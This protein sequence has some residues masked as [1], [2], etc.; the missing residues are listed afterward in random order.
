MRLTS[1]TDYSLRVLM[2]LAVKPE[3]L[4]TIPDIAKA[5][6]ISEN[7]LMKVVHAM[8]QQGWLATTRGKGGG[9]H[10]MDGYVLD[11][12][13]LSE[14][15][16]DDIMAALSALNRTGPATMRATRRPCA[17]AACSTTV[18]TY[19]HIAFG[20]HVCIPADATAITTNTPFVDHFL[21]ARTAILIQQ[22]R[23]LF[24]FV[25]F[26]WL[27]H[28]SV[29]FCALRSTES[30]ELLFRQ[31]ILRQRF[32]QFLVSH[33]S[34]QHLSRIVVQRNNGRRLQVRVGVHEILQIAAED[35]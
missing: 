21:A 6:A 29:E 8:A 14:R 11:R 31:L 2:Y 34:L 17:S 15:E 9:V 24:R 10:L 1:F 7:H 22:H 32:L 12:S 5:Y 19:Y 28:P 16:Q 25:E 27:N 4:A 30:K 35:G 33:Q 26:G 13:V 20:S 3:Q 23:I 18:H